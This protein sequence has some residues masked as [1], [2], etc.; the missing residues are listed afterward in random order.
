[1]Y[2]RGVNVHG[3]I[4]I[5]KLSAFF[6]PGGTNAEKAFR[7]LERLSAIFPPGGTLAEPMYE[8]P[9]FVRRDCSRFHTPSVHSIRTGAERA[10]VY[11]DTVN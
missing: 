10:W 8:V 9:G 1:M 3:P 6:P 5:R 4:H 7:P 11:K 2:T